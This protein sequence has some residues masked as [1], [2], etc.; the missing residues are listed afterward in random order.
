[1]G[2]MRDELL[3]R[4]LLGDLTADQ[5][6]PP[7]DRYAAIRCRARRHRL[8]QAAGT[9]AVVVAAAGLAIGIGVSASSVA[10]ASRP[11]SVPSWA[12]PWPDH[13]NGSV[14][15]HVLDGAV[16]AWRHEIALRAGTPL[17]TTAR[18]KVIWY[19]GQTV[20]H[21][22]SVVVI[23]EVGSPAGPR[24]VAGLATASEVTSGQPGW[25]RGF[26][27][28][29]LYD[30]PAPQRAAGLA[31]GLNTDG[32]ATVTGRNPDDWIVVLAAPQVRDVAFTASGPSR[33]GATTEVLGV[34]TASHGL[35]IGD[36][37][38]VSGPVQ[39][40]KLDVG[41]HNTLAVPVNVEVPGSPR[42]QTPQ[43]AM[44]APIRVP[45]GLSEQVALT[46]QGSSGS[47]LTTQGGR[48][49][50]VARCYGPSP[51]RLTYRTGHGERAIGTITCDDG[52]HELITKIRLSH[53]AVG[54]SVHSS[55]LTAFRVVI[56]TVR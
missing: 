13:R 1:M 35:L 47:S 11:R 18:A 46:G 33:S 43:L 12:L 32:P 30:V 3:V 42:S 26:S 5:P 44:P 37:G 7:A 6:A 27:P 39:L 21:G 49:A 55:P 9:L 53:P 41:H 34:G 10:P 54:V 24:L 20:A 52:A 25:S 36:V 45:P 23:F 29:V 4:R 19:V 38:Q 50:I 48:L 15:Q 14:P 8:T 56:G 22:Q 31:I 40:T 16:A 2:V 28:W 51:L 17:G